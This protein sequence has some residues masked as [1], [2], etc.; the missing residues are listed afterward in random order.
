MKFL[1]P[2]Y[3]GNLFAEKVRDGSSPEFSEPDVPVWIREENGL[4]IVLGPDEKGDGPPEVQIERQ[5][6]GW[7][8]F[9]HPA[10]GG[11]PSGYAYLLDDGRSF[12]IKESPIGPTVAIKVLD[13]D[14]RIEGI[15]GI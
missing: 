11:D 10:G 2:T 8:V 13:C 15:H 5:P 6:N 7:A 14:E 9:L 4:R 3:F 1:V 12:L